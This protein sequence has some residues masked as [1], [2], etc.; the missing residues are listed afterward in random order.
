MN[1]Y[2]NPYFS[3]FACDCIQR[4]Y[5]RYLYW[6]NKYQKEVEEHARTKKE[7]EKLK[8]STGINKETK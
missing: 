3:K 5:Q 8:M 7:L 1:N 6:E 4:L 2:T